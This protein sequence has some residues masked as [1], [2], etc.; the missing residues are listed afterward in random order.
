MKETKYPKFCCPNCGIATILDFYPKSSIAKWKEFVCPN[1]GFNQ[2]NYSIPDGLRN[3]YHK[4][5]EK[6]IE[7]KKGG[8]KKIKGKNK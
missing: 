7:G 4:R 5:D 3:T 8:K 1:C 2:F 6:K